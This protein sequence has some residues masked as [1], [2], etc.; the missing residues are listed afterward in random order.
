MHA[1]NSTGYTHGLQLGYDNA[2]VQDLFEAQM[3]MKLADMRRAAQ[4]ELSSRH[5]CLPGAHMPERGF[6]FLKNAQA[7]SV[8]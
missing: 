2:F 7:G 8:V 4:A 1:G 3:G 5:D 6:Y